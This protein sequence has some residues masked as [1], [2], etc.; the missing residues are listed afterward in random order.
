[1]YRRIPGRFR[2]RINVMIDVFELCIVD[3]DVYASEHVNDVC[4]NLEIYRD[5]MLDIQIQAGIEHA[6]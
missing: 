1:M 3:I 2:C 4:H 5:V 6:A